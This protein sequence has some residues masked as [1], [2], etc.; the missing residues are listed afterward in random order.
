VAV[1][2]LDLD[3]TLCEGEWKG[4]AR[5]VKP[6]PERV[7]LARALIA[8]GERVAILTA[9]PSALQADTEAWVEQ[10]L[11]QRVPCFLW[12]A[13]SEFSWPQY[14]PWKASVLKEQ[15]A[16]LYVGDLG[17]DAKAAR[18]AGVPFVLAE[19]WR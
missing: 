4:D 14:A 5:S 12:P 13:D 6:L 7:A 3:G 17:I 15:G 19:E 10:H 8:A 16:S 11:G 18:L 2:I 1:K 9:R